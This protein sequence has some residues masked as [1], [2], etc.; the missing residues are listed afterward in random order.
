MKTTGVETNKIWI[1]QQTNWIC[2]R[3][4]Q[5]LTKT[6]KRAYIMRLIGHIARSTFS[7]EIWSSF[8]GTEA[9]PQARSTTIAWGLI[10]PAN[11]VQF[12]ERSVRRIIR[13]A[14]KEGLVAKAATIAPDGTITVSLAEAP[15]DKLSVDVDMNEWDAPHGKPSA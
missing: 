2:F 7:T 9:E 1:K 5:N 12:R 14:L 10:M 11:K 3:T 15:K 13:A 8:A 4:K 6:A